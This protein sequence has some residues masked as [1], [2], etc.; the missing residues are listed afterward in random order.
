MEKNAPKPSLLLPSDPWQVPPTSQTQRESR[1]QGSPGD[2][3][4]RSAPPRSA[5]QHGGRLKGADGA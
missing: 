5:E 1:G 4:C 2:A 3:I